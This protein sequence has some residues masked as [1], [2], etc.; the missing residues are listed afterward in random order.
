[1]IIKYQKGQTPYRNEKK[2]RKKKGK[3]GK[4]KI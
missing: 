3:K 1:V 2:E 4:K